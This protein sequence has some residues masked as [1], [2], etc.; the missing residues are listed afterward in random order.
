VSKEPRHCSPKGTKARIT[1]GKRDERCLV[2]NE[3]L[4][5]TGDTKIL[6]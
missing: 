3:S 1:R 5:K 4:E 6:N 2:K